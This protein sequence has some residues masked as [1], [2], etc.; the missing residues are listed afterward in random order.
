MRPA[1][2]TA[3]ILLVGVIALLRAGQASAYVRELTSTGMPVAWKSPCITMQLFLGAPPQAL[4]ADQYLRAATA[5]ASVWSQPTLACSDIRLGVVANP[6]VSADVAYDQINSIA[7][8][9]AAWCPSIASPAD[10]PSCY[11]HSALAITTLVKN[12]NTGEILDADTVFNA[13]DYTWA[14]IVPAPDPMP[15]DTPDFQNAITHELGHV[16]GLAHSCYAAADKQGRLLDN[17]GAPELDCYDN[18]EL[19]D[20]IKESTMYPSVSL[21][22]TSRRDLGE[23]DIQGVCDIYPYSHASCDAVPQLNKGGGCATLGQ[24]TAVARSFPAAAAA[25]LA[26]IL[27]GLLYRRKRD[28][29]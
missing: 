5:G 6:A 10:D 9:N 18:P 15:P 1:K 27:L 14:D 24:A 26:T 8:R 22:D 20:A 13:V 7:F 17:T 21:P 28:R 2:T 12:K 19:P 29:I 3:S 23:D 16:I 25:A 4:T 11:P